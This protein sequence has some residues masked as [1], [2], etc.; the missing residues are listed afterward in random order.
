MTHRIIKKEQ[1][2]FCSADSTNDDRVCLHKRH[3]D[4]SSIEPT[5]YEK[6]GIKEKGE[7]EREREMEERGA[8]RAER[9]GEKR[10]TRLLIAYTRCKLS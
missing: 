8:R 4:K 6:R 1:N 3:C 10:A 2:S 5:G 9:R 7:R